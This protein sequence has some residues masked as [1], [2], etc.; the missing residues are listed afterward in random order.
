MRVG[1]DL[2][3]GDEWFN[4]PEV[5]AK[6]GLDLSLC[7]WGARAL[8]EAVCAHHAVSDYLE[9]HPEVAARY[10]TNQTGPVRYFDVLTLVEEE[11]S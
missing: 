11:A 1:S 6:Y 9:R 4:P 10:N 8:Y 2:A 7:P 3:K 5:W